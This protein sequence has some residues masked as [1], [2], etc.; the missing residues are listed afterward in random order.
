M[1]TLGPWIVEELHDGTQAILVEDQHMP[2][3]WATIAETFTMSSGNQSHNAHLIAAAP[4][5]LEALEEL[6]ETFTATLEATPKTE[7]K[8]GI[9]FK[10]VSARAK[11]RQAIKKARANE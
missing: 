1:F 7:V 2:T 9:A 5:L 10:I 3:G 8:V 6:Q 4:D 11:A